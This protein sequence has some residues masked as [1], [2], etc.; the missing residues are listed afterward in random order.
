MLIAVSH[1]L[2]AL[3]QERTREGALAGDARPP[4]R[5]GFDPLPTEGRIYQKNEGRCVPQRS[6]G[7]V[8]RQGRTL[9]GYPCWCFR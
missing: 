9:S 3:V 2:P 1:I 5:Q 7:L 4:P 8:P 6:A